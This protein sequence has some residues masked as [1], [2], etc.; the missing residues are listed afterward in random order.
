MIIFEN[1]PVDP[2]LPPNSNKRVIISQVVTQPELIQRSNEL[3]E[4][5]K[6]EQYSDYCK[7]KVDN[8]TDIHRKKIWNCV[9]AYFSE[10][11]AKNILNLLGYNI[12]TMNNKLNQLVSQ[13]DVNSI[14]E[15]VGNLNN[16]SLILYYLKNFH[17]II[18]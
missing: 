3:E 4:V 16:V 1:G 8:T 2:N 18:T 12:E 9:G 10:N 5:L 7:G 15:G 14:T 13:E 6:T 11:V 17:S